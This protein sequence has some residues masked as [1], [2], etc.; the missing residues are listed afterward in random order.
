MNH[1]EYV[2]IIG[3]IVKS[4]EIADRNDVQVR[5]IE[6]LDKI[7]DK[8]KEEIA[9]NFIITAGDE[10]QGLLKSK[11]KI[12]NILQDLD[13]EMYPVKFRYGVGIGRVTSTINKLKSNEV[14]GPAFHRAR[15]MIELIEENENGNQKPITNIM[16]DSGSDSDVLMN[17]TLSLMAT[18]KKTWTPRQTEVVYAYL[19]NNQ[20]QH[21]TADALN[22]QQ[23]T[24]NRSLN[25]AHYYTFSYAR[26]QLHQ[27]LQQK[28]E[29]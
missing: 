16:I 26:N 25:A 20:N 11:K 3:D 15:R 24:V 29:H 19:D 17:A 27:Y 7:N 18:L 6:V 8:Y 9:A 1:E 28:E 14:D 23:S 13:I 5:F 2:V 12:I 4:R 22:V 10:F 21:L